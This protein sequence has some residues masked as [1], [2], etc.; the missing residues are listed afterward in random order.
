MIDARRSQSWSFLFSSRPAVDWREL[1]G[2]SRPVEIEIGCGKGAFLLAYAEKHPDTNLLGIEQQRRWIRFVEARLSGRHLPNVR[3]LCADAA[4]VIA[5]FV[6]DQSVRAY[7]ALFPDPWW[8]RRHEKRRWF[9]GEAIDHL[10]RTLEPKGRIYLATDVRE[11]F[12]AM[13]EE[14][15]TRP[16]EI[17]I[18][19]DRGERP[20]T[21]FETKYGTEGRPLYYA[22]LEK[23]GQGSVR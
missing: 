15:S 21:N 4:L 10:V 20:A 12:E 1:F 7:H 16:F 2:N 14:L 17:T 22:T 9:R 18:E 23:S 19:K 3:V 5:R 11:R 6:P 8:K 13:I